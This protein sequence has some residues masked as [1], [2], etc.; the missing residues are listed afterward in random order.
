MRA[1]SRDTRSMSSPRFGPARSARPPR[2]LPEGVVAEEFLAGL[3]RAGSS[4]V[5]GLPDSLLACLHRAAAAAEAIKYVPVA[6]E[7]DMPGIAAGIHLGGGRALLLMENSGIRQ[8]CEPLARFGL[9]HQLPIVM[10]LSFRG[11]LGE[12]E[13]WGHSHAQT[14]LPLLDALRIPYWFVKGE[15]RLQRAIPAAFAHAESGQMPVAL[16]MRGCCGLDAA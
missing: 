16:I 7:S 1:S 11:D 14:M 15:W 10:L 8:A 12:A 13:W 5:I 3:R 2:P 4:F 9:T 6:S